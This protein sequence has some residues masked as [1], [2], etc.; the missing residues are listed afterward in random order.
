MAIR[1]RRFLPMV[2][3]SAL[4]VLGVEVKL[5]LPE[6]GF[7]SNIRASSMC[8]QVQDS[9]FVLSARCLLSQAPRR[10]PTSSPAPASSHSSQYRV[11]GRNTNVRTTRSRQ[12][13]T[14]NIHQAGL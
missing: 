12:F 9:L 14:A 13:F 10:G 5:H 2:S 1:G 7:C 6:K 11:L 3:T 4:A 8:S